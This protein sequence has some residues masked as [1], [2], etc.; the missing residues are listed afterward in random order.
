MSVQ[1]W[2]QRFSRHV[3]AV[4]EKKW[5]EDNDWLHRPKV[6]VALDV[7]AEAVSALCLERMCA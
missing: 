3:R 1:Q 7:N 6:N 4:S 5:V 2:Q